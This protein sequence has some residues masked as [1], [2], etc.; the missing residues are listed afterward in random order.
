MERRW[1]MSA[2]AVLAATA[3]PAL[4]DE[5]AP[6][7]PKPEATPSQVAPLVD[8]TKPLSVQKDEEAPAPRFTYGFSADAYFSSGFNNPDPAFN[9]LGVFDIKDEHGIH[10]GLVDIWAQLARQPVGGRIDLNF[11]PTGRFTNF[12]EAPVSG[13]DLWNHVQ[14]AYLSFNTNK[15]GTEYIDAGRFVTSA[16]SE[17]IEPKDNW[18]YT[19]GILFGW[20]IPFSHTGI[21]YTNYANETDYYTLQVHRGWDTVS[22]PGSTPGF[23]IGG[24]KKLNDEWSVLGIYYGGEEIGPS[25]SSSYR[26]LVDVVANYTPPGKIA[27]NFNFDFGHQSGALW[28][29]LAGMAK[30]TLSPK[31]YLAARAEFM[32]DNDGFRFGTG[33][34]TTAYEFT[35]GYQRQ[36]HPNFQTR[37]E[38]RHDFSGDD[39]FPDEGGGVTDGQG[40]FIVSGILSYK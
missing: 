14:Q 31:D 37:F 11:G 35:L 13:D 33:G 30:Y 22:D 12:A 1:L 32:V 34:N 21:R 18:L 38:Y 23:G 16:G 3:A 28:Y 39:I 9:G 36:W 20:A 24:G 40:R 5:K 4:A 27:Y 25:G 15:E 19:R 6:E 8:T 17:V 10:L 2:L 7:A 29:G 26:S